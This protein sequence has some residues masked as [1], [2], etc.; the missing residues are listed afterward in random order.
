MLAPIEV[1][2]EEVQAA[3]NLKHGNRIQIFP[4]KAWMPKEVATSKKAAQFHKKRHTTVEKAERP[5]RI[6]EIEELMETDSKNVLHPL[7][8]DKLVQADACIP[9]VQK[10][11]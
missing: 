6:G 8:L 2:I 5:I 7:C 11:V 10:L 3:A 9:H 1:E 4:M